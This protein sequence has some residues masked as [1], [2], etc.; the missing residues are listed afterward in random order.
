MNNMV[1][2]GLG[3]VGAVLLPYRWTRLTGG[4]VIALAAGLATSPAFAD[5]NIMVADNGVVE[6]KASSKDLTRISLKQDK[7]ASISKIAMPDAQRDFSIV[8]EPSRGDIYLTVPEGFPRSSISFFGTT[9]KGFVYKFECKID[10]AGAEQIFVGNVDLERTAM[11]GTSAGLRSPKEKSIMLVQAMVSQEIV[12][13]YEIRQRE[14]APVRVGNLRVQM[15]SEYRGIDLQG[16]TLRIENISKKQV[17]LDEAQIGSGD[18]IAVSVA[19]NAL[20]P[21]QITTAYVVTPMGDR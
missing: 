16:R 15:I 21:G 9:Q 14:L 20:K 4:C 18:A 6:C 13:G 12:P 3:C 11:D 5:Q 7:F 19:N 17:K 10:G 1:V 2:L 8:N